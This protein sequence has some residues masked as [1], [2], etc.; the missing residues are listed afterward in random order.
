MTGPVLTTK[1]L[2][3]LR[4]LRVRE[5]WIMP[6]KLVSL[7]LMP[8]G[9]SIWGMYITGAALYRKGLIQRRSWLGGTEFAITRAGFDLL[10]SEGAVVSFT[11]KQVE[12]LSA[13]RAANEV[14]HVPSK[15]APAGRREFH[16][17]RDLI[18]AR[19]LDSAWTYRGACVV[20]AS[21]MRR[22]LVEQRRVGPPRN[23]GTEFSITAL[24]LRMLSAWV[25]AH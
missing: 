22:G 2:A 10:D 24:G 5:G 21:L 8:E 7:D 17:P 19:Q 9:T 15:A 3:M 16:N 13:L 1:Q 18:S 12:L 14:R 6:G 25:A 23:Y 11:D 20:G 4:A